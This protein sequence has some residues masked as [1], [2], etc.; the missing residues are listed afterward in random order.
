MCVRV[1]VKLLCCTASD[2]GVV[3]QH[4]KA[5][6]RRMRLMEVNIDKVTLV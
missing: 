2:D 1:F 6:E 5:L 3:L 4:I